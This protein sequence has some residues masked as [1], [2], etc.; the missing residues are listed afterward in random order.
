M[1]N[2]WGALIIAMGVGILYWAAKH[3]GGLSDA[4]GS[5]ESAATGGV[6]GPSGA[7]QLPGTKNTGNPFAPFPDFGTGTLGLGI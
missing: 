5:A 1:G 4:L 7:I 3:T 6:V 2:T